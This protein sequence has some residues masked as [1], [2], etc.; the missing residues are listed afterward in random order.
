MSTNF[1]L[2]RRAFTLTELLIVLGILGVIL[3]VV[4]P[5][6][7]SL[8]KASQRAACASNMRHLHT[9]LLAYALDNDNWL[10]YA[11]VSYPGAPGRDD[12]MLTWDDLLHKYLGEPLSQ[13][14]QEAPARTKLSPPLYCPSDFYPRRVPQLSRQVLPRSYAM[15]RAYGYNS[16]HK[17]VFRGIGGQVRGPQSLVWTEHKA[18]STRLPWLTRGGQVLLMV[19]SPWWGNILGGTGGYVDEPMGHWGGYLSIFNRANAG[20]THG[21][22]RWNYLFSDGS[23]ELRPWEDMCEPKPE[24]QMILLPPLQSARPRAEAVVITSNLRQIMVSVTI[25][26]STTSAMIPTHPQFLRYEPPVNMSI[27]DQEHVPWWKAL[28]KGEIYPPDFRP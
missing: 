8:R 11:E 4:L 19:E 26:E 12:V 22:G 3:A 13:A 14:E 17:R 15:V 7:S 18:L 27:D 28:F 21:G 25:Y 10:P 9:A 20:S 24:H 2:A 1:R 5:T 16:L 23:V 6:L